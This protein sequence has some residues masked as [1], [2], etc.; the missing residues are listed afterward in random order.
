MSKDAMNS[1]KETTMQFVG[2]DP[3]GKLR[4]GC[5]I[6]AEAAQE[7]AK[8][9]RDKVLL[10][11]SS[12]VRRLGGEKAITDSLDDMGIG[13]SIF[14]DVEPEPSKKTMDRILETVRSEKFGSVIGLGG[15]SVLD[16]AKFAAA[17]AVCELSTD[18]MFS[19]PEKIV[20]SL[21]T[22]L[23]PTTSGTGSEV[24]P[25]I[26]MSDGDKKRFIGRPVLY[27]TVAMVDP[28][29][30]VSMPPRVTAFT[31]LDALTHGIEGAIGKTTPYTLAMAAQCAKLVFKYLPRAV[32][33]GND[34]EARYYMS[35]AAVLGMMAYTQG[36][37]LYAHSM[38]YVLTAEKKLPHGAGCGLSLP[39]TLRYSEQFITPVLE[40]LQL[41]LG[42]DD[43]P[44]AVYELVKAVNAPA[45]LKELGFEENELGRLA[46][47]L[48][49][50][51]PRPLNP[52]QMSRE[53]AREFMGR[54]YVG[55]IAKAI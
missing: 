8:L 38:S 6:A 15:G 21:P 36:G 35:Y 41:A 26:V 39:Y 52:R 17:A 9:S 24:S 31:G 43:V 3:A 5:G 40:E 46:D 13:Y 11:V 14:S 22:V 7:A 25:Y 51:Y 47:T 10:I 49:D 42:V 44:Q 4:I 1:L 29:L 55:E 16:T 12:T 53:D 30:T 23:L 37:G 18:E 45:T 54:M 28:L 2:T 27:A 20:S 19:Q 34:I 50:V 48:V 32:K 33:D